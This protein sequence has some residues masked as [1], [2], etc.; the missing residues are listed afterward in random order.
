M[1]RRTLYRPLN[2]AN[3]CPVQWLRRAYVQLLLLRC[4]RYGRGRWR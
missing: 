4:C 1:V 2:L 3:A